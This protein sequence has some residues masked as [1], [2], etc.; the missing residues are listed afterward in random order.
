MPEAMVRLK[1]LGSSTSIEMSPM[2]SD[3][4]VNWAFRSVWTTHLRLLTDAMMYNPSA[5][6]PSP[7]VTVPVTVPVPVM[8]TV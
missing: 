3:A 5:D 7:R 8:I 6:L 2:G 1:S 4:N